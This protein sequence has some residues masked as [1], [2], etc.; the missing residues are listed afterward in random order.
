MLYKNLLA[1]ELYAS[2]PSTKL[3]AELFEKGMKMG[4]TQLAV[5]AMEELI[6]RGDT[7]LVFCSLKEAFD[8]E[9]GYVKLDSSMGSMIARSLLESDRGSDPILRRFGKG[10]FL[11]KN[12]IEFATYEQT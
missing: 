4:S 5:S 7:D 9:N 2:I 1:K 10:I 3:I 12:P 11:K 6:L 8:T